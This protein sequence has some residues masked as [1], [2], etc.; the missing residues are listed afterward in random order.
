MAVPCLALLQQ[1]LVDVLGRADIHPARGLGGD[2]HLR[3]ARQLAR[4]DQ[5][6]DVAAG[7]VLDRR[8]QR[9]GS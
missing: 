1:A 4:H 2:Q 3:A 7:Q 9:W 6:L 8:I 5:L